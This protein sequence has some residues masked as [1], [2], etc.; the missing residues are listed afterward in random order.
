VTANHPL[1]EV[2]IVGKAVPQKKKNKDVLKCLEKMLSVFCL[3]KLS[4]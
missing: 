1:G 3:E 2:C 4:N